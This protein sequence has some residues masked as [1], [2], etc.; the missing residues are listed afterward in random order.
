M[1]EQV[2]EILKQEVTAGKPDGFQK[3][4]AGSADYDICNY[5]SP[6]TDGVLIG[7]RNRLSIQVYY[8]FK[9]S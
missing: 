8:D 3:M 2:K 1:D 9:L 6:D 7:Y 5:V 4:L